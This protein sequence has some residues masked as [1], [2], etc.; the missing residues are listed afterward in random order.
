M[1]CCCRLNLIWGEE[2]QKMHTRTV[3]VLLMVICSLTFAY[4][5]FQSLKEY[6]SYNTVSKQKRERQEEQPMPQICLTSP[7]LAEERLQKLGITSKEYT[8]EGVWTSSLANYSTTSED[9]IKRMVFPDLTEMLNSVTVRSRIGKFSDVYKKRDYKSEEILNGT[10]IKLFKL[11]YYVYFTV[12]CF[13][14]PSSSFPF[15]VEKV[16]FDMKTKCKVLLVSPGNFLSFDRKRNRLNH[17]NHMKNYEYQVE[18]QPLN[19]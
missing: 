18:I 3:Q 16:S 10:D 19:R 14:F 5:A 9:E 1:F 17:M 2:D 15:G 12:Y 4:Y 7:S 13:S 6:L 11:H 8:K